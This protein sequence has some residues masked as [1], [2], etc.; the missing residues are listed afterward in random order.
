MQRYNC[1]IIDIIDII[2]STLDTDDDDTSD[3]KK[4][5]VTTALQWFII[6]C[7]NTMYFCVICGL[8]WASSDETGC[9]WVCVVCCWGSLGCLGLA[10]FIVLLVNIGVYITTDWVVFG[11]VFVIA[12]ISVITTLCCGVGVLSCGTTG[13]GG[14]DCGGCRVM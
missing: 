9:G 7:G 13:G 5:T 2:K 8:A 11:W 6:M 3:E 12:N 1:S 4:E 10:G 14:G